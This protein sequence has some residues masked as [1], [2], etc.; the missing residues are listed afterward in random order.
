MTK[1]YGSIQNRLEENKMFCNKIE[2]GT[3]LTEY[4]Y[5]DCHPYEVVEVINQNHVYVRALDY[6]SVG[7]AMSNTW[8]LV[9]NPNNKTLELKKRYGFWNWVKRWKKEDLKTCYV[10]PKNKIYDKLIKDGVATEYI[11]TNISFGV[12]EYYYD[13]TK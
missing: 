12:G 4:F 13:Y 6:K 9:S 2:K 8:E 3:L 10:F 11:R 1:W 5:S 7:P